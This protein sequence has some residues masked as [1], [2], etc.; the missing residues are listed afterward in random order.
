M[1]VVL[2]RWQV[3]GEET[4]NITDSLDELGNTTAAI[5]KGFALAAALAACDYR[6]IC[7]NTFSAN[8]RV[9]LASW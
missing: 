6:C 2:L 1:L 3:L 5:G 4:R 9:Y 7:R 8:A